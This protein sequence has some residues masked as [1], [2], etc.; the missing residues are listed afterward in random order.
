MPRLAFGCIVVT[1]SALI[2]MGVLMLLAP[3]LGER[4]FYLFYYLDTGP[5][6]PF[7]EEARAYI[8]FTNMVLGAVLIGWMVL[9]L[10]VL[11]RWRRTDDAAYLSIIA[12]SVL[13]W[14]VPDTIFSAAYGIWGNVALNGAGALG[15][16][17]PI[18][19]L[20]RRVVTSSP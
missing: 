19:L 2:A 3:P 18:A 5:V 17:L 10:L 16:L 14:F 20:R 7:S 11:R 9:T 6:T 12:W 1:A 8:R 4:L 15:I 13:A